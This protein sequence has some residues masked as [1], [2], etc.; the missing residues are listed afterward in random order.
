MNRHHSNCQIDRCQVCLADHD[1]LR[2]HFEEQLGDL[3]IDYLGHYRQ[4][5]EKQGIACQSE[6]GWGTS[7]YFD[8]ANIASY[9]AN[10]TEEDE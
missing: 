7:E 6:D 10:W 8:D 3:N 5:L 2:H 4:F 1:A 9:I